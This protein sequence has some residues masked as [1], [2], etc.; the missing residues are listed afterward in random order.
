MTSIPGRVWAILAFAVG[1]GGCATGNVY[2]FRN[3]TTGQTAQCE[4]REYGIGMWSPWG[5]GI[6]HAF[7][8]ECVDKLKERGFTE[9]VFE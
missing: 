6:K 5:G 7:L 4:E 3:P 8:M 2:T 1:L 9:Q